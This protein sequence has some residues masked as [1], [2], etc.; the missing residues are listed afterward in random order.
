MDVDEPL[1]K[2]VEIE[3][4]VA[5]YLGCLPFP[6]AWVYEQLKPKWDMEEAQR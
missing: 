4:Q 6:E 1:V 5:D 2:A 3:T